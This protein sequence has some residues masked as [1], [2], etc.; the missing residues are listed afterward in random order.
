MIGFLWVQQSL[1]EF[2][3]NLRASEGSRRPSSLMSVS[4]TLIAARGVACSVW[5]EDVAAFG[6]RGQFRVLC[7]RRLGRVV[8]TGITQSC[9]RQGKIFKRD[10]IGLGCN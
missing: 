3:W 5:C 6:L 2:L 9:R 4:R 8:Q 10:S 7:V 1:G